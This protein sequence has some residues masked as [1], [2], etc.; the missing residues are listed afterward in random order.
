[1]QRVVAEVH[2]VP[3]S[4]P[5]I[6]ASRIFH[7]L[8]TVQ[9][10]TS[11]PVGTSVTERQIAS[12]DLERPPV[13]LSGEAPGIGNNSRINACI[14]PAG[15]RL[16]AALPASR[17]PALSPRLATVLDAAPH[18]LEVHAISKRV[19]RMPEPEVPGRRPSCPSRRAAATGRARDGAGPVDV[20]QGSRPSTKKPPLIHAPVSQRL[21]AELLDQRVSSLV[22]A[23]RTDPWP[24]SGHRRDPPLLPMKGDQ[25]PPM[26]T[27][28][29]PSPYVRQNV[30][31][32]PRAR[33]SVAADLR[34]SCPTPVSTSVT[35][36]GSVRRCG[37]ASSCSRRSNVTSAGA[38]K[39]QAK[40]SLIR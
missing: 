6:H 21:L 7:S 24:D 9:S 36:H 17:F 13:A 4:G 8:G 28:A 35:R 26:S 11:E 16:E 20:P 33:G 2:D 1:M 14:D 32:R 10:K 30:A 37:S 22:P 23:R 34:S 18:R 38:E 27:S 12:D 29:T 25:P 19:H 31:R 15:C 39:Y 3:P 40:Y 5:S